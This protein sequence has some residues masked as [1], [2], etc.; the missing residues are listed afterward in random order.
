VDFEEEFEGR[1]PDYWWE[2]Y[3]RRESHYWQRI[4]FYDALRKVHNAISIRA[5]AA[6]MTTVPLIITL[7]TLAVQYLQAAGPRPDPVYALAILDGMALIPSLWF[8]EAEF[9]VN[10]DGR[11]ARLLTYIARALAIATSAYSIY[12]LHL[13]GLTGIFF[14]LACFGYAASILTAVALF[15]ADG[16]GMDFFTPSLIFAEEEERRI[17]RLG[18]PSNSHPRPTEEPNQPPGDEFN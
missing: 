9:A 13:L 1:Q 5:T 11:H 6:I 18:A 17:R 14:A 8:V 4:G 15:L 12:G 7:T 16:L 2:S 10:P 3:F